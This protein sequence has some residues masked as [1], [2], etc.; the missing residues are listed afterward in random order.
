[1]MDARRVLEKLIALALTVVLIPASGVLASGQEK[2]AVPT[3]RGVDRS[4][5]PGAN[6]AGRPAVDHDDDRDKNS[7]ND[8]V[9]MIPLPQD[10]GDT[11]LK[12]ALRKLQTTGRLM[13]VTRTP[14][15]KTAAC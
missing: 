14:T 8:A 12:M 2:Q 15:M 9:I 11:G 1:M 7:G 10:L 13:Q 3:D 4:T 6:H 5:A